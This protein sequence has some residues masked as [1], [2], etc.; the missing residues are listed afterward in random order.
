MNPQVTRNEI[1]RYIYLFGLALSV[2]CLS[3][4]PYLLSVSQFLL[5]LNWIVEG[6]FRRKLG[7]LKTNRAL[8]LFVLV[9]V[10]YAIGILFSENK[11]TALDKGVNML[12]LLAF[13][14][15]TSTSAPLSPK[16][17][18]RLLLLFTDAVIFAALISTIQF[19]PLAG[20][21]G[22]DFRQLSFFMS[23]IRFSLL[24]VMAIFIML[25]R[26]Y[27]GWQRWLHSE[28]VLM[29]LNALALTA[30]LFYLRSFT[31]LA[32]F[33]IVLILFILNMARL[34]RH[35][36]IRY[37]LAFMV[38]GLLTAALW[39]VIRTWNQN[40]RPAP[41][42][43]SN[44]DS[45]TANGNLYSHSLD[46]VPENGYYTELYVCEPELEKEWNRR[47]SLPYNGTDLKGQQLS[48]TLKRYLASA[49]LRKDSAAVS[50]LSVADMKSIETGL[51][52]I[53]FTTHPGIRQRLY[54]T[55]WELAMLKKTGFTYNH[56]L[57]QRITFIK[58][59]L[60][61]L[62]QHW[63]T[64]T[65]PG[66]VNSDMLNRAE[67]LKYATDM[68]WE[69]K[70]HNQYIFWMLAFGIPGF[71]F[72]L[73]C[74]TLPVYMRKAAQYQL[75]NIFAAIFLISMFAID[76]LEGYDSVAFFALFYCLFVF[77]TRPKK[78]ITNINNGTEMSS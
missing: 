56:T 65:G 42:N 77:G 32:I 55:L 21:T 23:H 8:L 72:I 43:I 69:G 5:A 4:S 11:N 13:A 28:K 47:S 66:D 71:V 39:F 60:S 74:L 63:L 18:D 30:F 26:A 75:F 9:F 67:M 35:N 22:T 53:R 34:S 44:L 78:K 40:F 7:A 16:T 1:H 57:G 61:L 50:R 19:L 70:P 46:G 45:H 27:A 51:A 64:G 38:G 36:L 76:T 31:G 17:F 73:L 15:I 49:G 68:R 10:A 52:N 24:V 20:E 58:V 59:S 6:D 3:L 25:Y 62:K 2:C 14:I 29:L 54:E 33:A 48:Q 41:V 37:V 12:P